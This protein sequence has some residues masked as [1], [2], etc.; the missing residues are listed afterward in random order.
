M[1]QS[2]METL[3]LSKHHRYKLAASSGK[4]TSG[5]NPADSRLPEGYWYA[6]AQTHN[7]GGYGCGKGQLRT[8]DYH[9]PGDLRGSDPGHAYPN[10][11]NRRVASS[12]HPLA[13]RGRY[14]HPPMHAPSAWPDGCDPPK[15]GGVAGTPAPGRAKPPNNGE[16]LE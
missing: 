15:A 10:V 4:G 6:E 16:T 2:E 13:M 5:H 8:R 9:Q 7:T 12:E 3:L 11:R 1:E 14:A